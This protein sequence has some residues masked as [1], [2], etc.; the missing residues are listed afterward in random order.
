MVL[1]SHFPLHIRN[2]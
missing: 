1:L 2:L